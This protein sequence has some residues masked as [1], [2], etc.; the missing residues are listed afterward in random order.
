MTYSALC[1][2]RELVSRPTVAGK[3]WPGSTSGGRPPLGR[4]SGVVQRRTLVVI[5]EF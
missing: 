4:W 3:L 5:S 2:S 1:E